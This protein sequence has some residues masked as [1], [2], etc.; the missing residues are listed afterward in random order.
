MAVCCPGVAARYLLRVT[1]ARNAGGYVV[2]DFPFWVRNSSLPEDADKTDPIKVPPLPRPSCVPILSGG[3]ARKQSPN[4]HDALHLYCIWTRPQMEVGI[5]DCLHIEFEYGK[6]VY[7]L[8]DT[9]VGKI[10]FLLVRIKL[11][12]MEIEIRRRE[13]TGT[14]ANLHNESETLAKYEIMDGAPVRG[15]NVPI[16]CAPGPCT[17]TFTLLPPCVRPR[18]SSAVMRI[19]WMALRPAIRRNCALEHCFRA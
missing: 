17:H 10:Y 8:L 13:T 11:K 2:K 19:V 6:G 12:H 15:E 18:R 1:V 16:R 9:V 7:S 5:E 14:G 3:R 4:A